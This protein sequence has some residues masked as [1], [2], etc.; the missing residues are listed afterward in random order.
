MTQASFWVDLWFDLL[1]MGTTVA[2]C[3]SN[4]DNWLLFVYPRKEK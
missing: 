1:T 2:K 3:R 4:N